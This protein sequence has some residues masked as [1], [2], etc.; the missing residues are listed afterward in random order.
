MSISEVARDVFL[1]RLPL[2]FA[3]NSV[4]C[5][6]LRDPEGW[7]VFDTG[8]HTPAG[9]AAWREGL[10]SLELK[11]EAI[12]RIIVSHHHP[13]HYGMAGWLQDLTGAPVLMASREAELADGIWGKPPD[14]P[15]PMVALFTAHGTPDDLVAT[16]ARDVARLRAATLPHPRV[17]FITPGERLLMAGRHFV[18]LHA[19]GHSDG[20]LIFFDEADGLLLCGDHLLNTIT[21]HIGVW[22][23]SEPNPLGRYLASLAELADVPVRL[24]LPGH[25]SLIQT[26]RERIGELQRHHADRLA[27]MRAA[28]DG[29]ATAYEVARRVFLF[30]QYTTHEM[31]FAVA[32]TIAH[33][34]YLVHAEGLRR[35]EGKVVRYG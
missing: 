16:I 18:A 12:Q 21:P 3:L 32:E 35:F 17:R 27:A 11:P 5:Y 14:A 8:L 10:A 6:L 23:G 2:P 9:E 34:E 25:K 31:R 19:P 15:E 1:V 7:T 30:D 24:A 20:Q 13:D 33:L 29:G 26:W 4:N 28:L 22:P